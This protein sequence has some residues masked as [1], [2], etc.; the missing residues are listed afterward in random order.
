MA[1][2][3]KPLLTVLLV[4]LLVL[5]TGA[6]PSRGQDPNG[7][8]QPT[9]HRSGHRPF[10]PAKRATVLPRENEE[11]KPDRVFHMPSL[12]TTA[13]GPLSD[14]LNSCH[15]TYLPQPGFLGQPLYLTLR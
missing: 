12:E 14:H 5:S 8:S 3:A 7:R 13:A 11:V 15:D 4:W 6:V 9:R 2:I 1:R 10:L